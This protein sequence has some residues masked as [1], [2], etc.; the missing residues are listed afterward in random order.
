M[1]YWSNGEQEYWSNG[2]QEY[3]SNGL[4]SILQHSNTPT[5]LSSNP[6]E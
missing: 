3:W 5:P 2:E 1:S 4:N 6:V